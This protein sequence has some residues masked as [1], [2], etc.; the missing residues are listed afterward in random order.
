MT[1]AVATVNVLAYKEE[2]DWDQAWMEN[3]LRAGGRLKTVGW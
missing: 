2:R 1:R 3:S